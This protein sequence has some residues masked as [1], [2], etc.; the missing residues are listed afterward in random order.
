MIISK[1]LLNF[2]R[3]DMIKK[4]IWNLYVYI[5]IFDFRHPKFILLIIYIINYYVYFYGNIFVS[6]VVLEKL[7]LFNF[8]K[9]Q[10][11]SILMNF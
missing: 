11:N 5:D 2:N 1:I 6:K 3:N 4:L 8:K 7:L 9:I 10:M